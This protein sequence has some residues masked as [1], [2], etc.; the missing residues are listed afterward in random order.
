MATSNPTR[1]RTANSKQLASSSTASTRAKQA[2]K[3]LVTR[4]PS[5]GSTS[6]L[7]ASERVDKSTTRGSPS[8]RS[9]SAADIESKQKVPKSKSD[10]SASS[11]APD[12]AV[13]ASI[14]EASS[15]SRSA[16]TVDTKHVPNVLKSK[17]DLPSSSKAAAAVIPPLIEE[18]APAPTSDLLQVAA[19]LYPW[20][21]MTSTLEACFQTAEAAAEKDLAARSQQLTEE[22]SEMANQR[23]RFHAERTADFYDE[24]SRDTLA[25]TAPQIMQTFL[26]HGDAC[27]RVEAEALHLATHGASEPDE[28]APLQVYGSMLDTLDE[29]HDEA[30]ELEV[31]ILNLTAD[32]ESNPASIGDPESG[33]VDGQIDNQDLSKDLSNKS[34][35]R[36]R[37]SA[38]SSSARVQIIGVF[39]ACLPV[40]RARIA[41]LSMAQD[42]IDS[43]QE[44][45]SISLRMESL[46]LLD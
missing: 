39:A 4:T 46:G 21:Y 19:Q 15:R 26:T 6:S 23:T 25:K 29:L 24:L 40:L 3:P 5:A 32:L 10:L 2:A 45:L 7:K 14:E 27:T 28:D 34:E 22:E 8:T 30:V 12:P 1:G 16:S 11:K 43:A 35:E 17:Q 41:N 36:Q 42:L 37:Y 38:A 31:S 33:G 9:A 13:A 20:L 44:N 18:K